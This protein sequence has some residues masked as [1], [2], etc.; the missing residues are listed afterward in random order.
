LQR[1]AQRLGPGNKRASRVHGE[2]EI[3]AYLGHNL[4]ITAK[5]TPRGDAPHI[6]YLALVR[7]FTITERRWQVDSTLVLEFVIS[8]TVSRIIHRPG[9][10][11]ESL[12][13]FPFALVKNVMISVASILLDDPLAVNEYAYR[14]RL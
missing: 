10:T 9:C 8:L 4:V 13:L 1:N 5:R 11:S 7:I 12:T 2:V 14:G 3:S 6:D